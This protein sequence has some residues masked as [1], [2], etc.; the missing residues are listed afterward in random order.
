MT[1]DH[2]RGSFD[3]LTW[4][5]HATLRGSHAEGADIA[6]VDPR[7]LSVRSLPAMVN[8]SRSQVATSAKTESAA[9]HCTL[10]SLGM[11]GYLVGQVHEV[12]GRASSC[13]D[14]TVPRNQ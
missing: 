10:S 11:L 6:R 8:A 3:E 7:T 2:R 9:P 1:Q 14:R 4:I 13:G 5:E 12:T